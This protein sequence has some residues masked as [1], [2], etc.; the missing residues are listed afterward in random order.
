MPNA[1]KDR[2]KT[3]GR[4][5]KSVVNNRL[6]LTHPPG[7]NL[8]ARASTTPP[9]LSLTVGGIDWDKMVE[10]GEVVTIPPSRDEV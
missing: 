3:E 4:S 5:R 9:I 1:C 6:R 7:A 10:E 8:A 2:A